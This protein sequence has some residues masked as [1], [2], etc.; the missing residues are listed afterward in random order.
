MTALVLLR[1]GESIWNQENRFTGSRRGDDIDRNRLGRPK[2]FAQLRSGL[3]VLI[4]NLFADLKD[5]RVHPLP[6]IRSPVPV[7]VEYLRS[8]FRIPGS[9]TVEFRAALFLADKPRRK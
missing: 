5:S 2:S 3:V 7:P 4:Q 9:E 1:H 6:S 8:G